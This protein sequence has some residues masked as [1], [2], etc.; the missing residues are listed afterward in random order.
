MKTHVVRSAL[1]GILMLGLAIPGV[2][3]LASMP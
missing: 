2:A 1:V 3:S